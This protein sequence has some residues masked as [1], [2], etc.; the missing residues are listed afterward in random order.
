MSNNKNAKIHKKRKIECYRLGAI[1]DPEY[2]YLKIKSSTKISNY[3]S[4]EISLLANKISNKL[5]NRIYKIENTFY[6]EQKSSIRYMVSVKKNKIE[7]VLIVP[8]VYKNLAMSAIEKT[9]NT[10][11][12][13]MEVGKE[14]VE[15][16]DSP[17]IFQ[18]RLKYQDALSL[19]HNGEKNNFLFNALNVVDIMGDGDC[20][21]FIVNLIPNDVKANK[22]KTLCDEIY[23][24]Y[25]KNES[26]EKR[27]YETSGIY[28]FG[29]LIA[30]F[31]DMCLPEALKF[32]T[33][34]K[35]QGDVKKLNE[36][37]LKKATLGHKVISAELAILTKA[38]SKEKEKELAQTFAMACS[39]IKLD[40]E[41]LLEEI[42]HPSYN[43]MSAHLSNL[44]L[45]KNKLTVYELSNFI[46]IAGKTIIENFKGI[47]DYSSTKETRVIDELKQGIV[48]LGVQQYRSKDYN[49]YLN[50]TEEFGYLPIVILT[51]MGGGKTTWLE[52]VG[53]ALMN[54]NRRRNRV[55]L[56]R[57][58]E[59]IVV[60][61]YI[62]QC[63]MSYNIMNNI[64][65]RDIVKVD[66]STEEGTRMLGMS[67]IEE[68]LP[69]SN[70][71]KII[72]A[73]NQGE[74][75]MKLINLL[76]DET[77][78]KL[79]ANMIRF[80]TSAFKVCFINE[81]QSLKNAFDIIEDYEIRHKYIDMIPRKMKK[82]LDTEIKTL[83]SLD[84]PEGG[85]RTG[86][87]ITGILSRKYVLE[88]TP[89]LKEMYSTKPESMINFYDLMQQGKAIFILMPDD[90]FSEPIINIIVSYVLSRLFFACK[91]RG[92]ISPHLVTRCT[93][94]I[95]E[96]DTAPSCLV[97]LKS[98]IKTFR[99]Y[100]LRPIFSA[101]DFD[102]LKEIEK[103]ANSV[104]FSII[105]PKGTS[106]ANFNSFKTE[107]N[108]Q[109]F[110]VEDLY[111]LKQYQTLNLIQTKEG[112]KAFV[113]TFPKPVPNKYEIISKLEDSKIRNF[114]DFK[115]PIDERIEP[116]QKQYRKVVEEDFE[117]D[118][119]IEPSKI[120]I[121]AQIERVKSKVNSIV[122]T[123]AKI[124][125]DTSKNDS[126]D[127]DI[128]DLGKKEYL[129]EEV[130][131]KS[132]KNTDTVSDLN[133]NE[134]DYLFETLNN[135]ENG[136]EDEY[137]D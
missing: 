7:F 122:S 72:A 86:A 116:Y 29:R 112:K 80:L 17:S 31:I 41:L 53:V 78:Q 70:R 52:T 134:F 103:R 21:Q 18:L 64:D 108:N 102:Q 37:S 57:P 24:R 20:L 32:N 1:R 98:K 66:L 45:D 69:K 81:N 125:R 114:E 26:I 27:A 115:R 91:Q 83:L 77:A 73:S 49:V 88:R 14:D 104:G 58:K 42:S 6:L 120:N 76:N 13:I 65:P 93:L 61:D 22:W 2:C 99:K 132:Y 39:D 33:E 97:E 4:E 131:V 47:I 85:T 36:T 63:E 9:W 136:Y 3:N 92:K 107:F 8:R 95:D 124:K 59:S 15:I 25:K 75:M 109:G 11:C 135:I 62:K 50:E 96:I 5:R 54:Y 130:N 101:H 43:N 55:L 28:S 79:T 84:T 67:F 12:N 127:S 71:D 105:L 100:K 44:G 16:L 30:Q 133:S 40:N 137:I 94:L 117:E 89:I 106:E 90:K 118:E 60:I 113:S 110:N 51:M 128:V 46:T 10:Q 74:E 82:K 123:N 111:E 34:Y 56:P 38:N 68:K 87:E 121:D 35:M 23:D 129:L 48:P 126:L 119:I 19:K